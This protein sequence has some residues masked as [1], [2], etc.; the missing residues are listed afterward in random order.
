MQVLRRGSRHFQVKLLQQL[1]NKEKK[2]AGLGDPFLTPDGDFGGL[3][4]SAL[5]AFQKRS[6]LVPDKIAGNK[7]W[8]ALGLRIE[9]EHAWVKL[10]GQTAQMSCWSAAAT[11][12]KGN[13]TVGP[14]RGSLDPT[15]GGLLSDA[16]SLRAF[17][18]GL[19]WTALNYSP[20]LGELVDTVCRTPVWIA[21]EGPNFGHAVVLSAVYSDGSNT[22]DGVLFRI[23]DPWPIGIGSIYGS[24]SDPIK[25]QGNL[26]TSHFQVIVPAY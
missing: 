15:S 5:Y 26:S 1:L 25:I 8:R 19:G 7:T 2:R 4:D 20:S 9:M 21:A 22:E 17:A 10:V 16:A 24:F 11:M 6:H 14:G 18:E 23:H 3:T 12:I 13:M